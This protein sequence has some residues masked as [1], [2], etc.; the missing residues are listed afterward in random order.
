MA[1][2]TKQLSESTV[3]RR[4]RKHGLTVVKSK[5][6]TPEEPV[7]G[8][9]GLYAEETGRW[10]KGGTMLADLTPD[11]AAEYQHS[12][13]TWTLEDI[14]AHLDHL[15]GLVKHVETVGTR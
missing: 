11:E 10:I 2:H 14:V 13:F 9:F 7:F 8:H 4:A 12:T 15:D 1:T 5:S 6:R 3:R